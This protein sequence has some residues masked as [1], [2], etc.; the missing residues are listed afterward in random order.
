[1][2]TTIRLLLFLLAAFSASAQVYYPFSYL[3]STEHKTIYL[4]ATNIYSSNITSSNMVLRTPQWI[5]VLCNYGYSTVGI[6]APGLIASASNSAISQ[7]AFDNNDQLFGTAQMP[8]NLAV[9]NASFPSLYIVPHVHFSVDK[10]IDATHTNVTWQ[11]VWQWANI[12]GSFISLQGTNS[13]TTGITQGAINYLADFTPITNNTAGISS[14]FR[15][16]LMRPAS[17]A[18][19]YSNAQD[20]FMNQLDLHVPIGNVV[21][22][23]SRDVTTQ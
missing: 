20:V 10:Y 6:N 13:V 16:R 4:Y 9:T 12:N 19:D 15:C 3:K 18:Q 21:I 2:K 5:D 22:L 1:M 23:G 8:H 7:L 14:L 11:L 17:V